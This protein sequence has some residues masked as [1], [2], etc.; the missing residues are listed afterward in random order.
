GRRGVVGA[1]MSVSRSRRP[2]MRDVAER[3][4]VSPMTVSRVLHDD[5]RVSP[6]TRRRVLK[7][8]DELGYRRNEVARNLRL[9]RT[10][11]LIGLV[12]T[13]LANPFYSQLA[14]GVEAVAAANGLKVV[15]TNTDE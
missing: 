6:E 8:V 4:S 3:S 1:A 9:G 11:G 12:V 2:T 10:S 5:P 15:L 13:N 14:L 7:A